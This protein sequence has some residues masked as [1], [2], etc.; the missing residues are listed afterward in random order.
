MERII[1]MV[2]DSIVGIMTGKCPEIPVSAY[3]FSDNR[4]NTYKLSFD[5]KNMMHERMTSKLC[6]KEPTA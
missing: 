5:N 2:G 4:P 6:D 1:G 3:I